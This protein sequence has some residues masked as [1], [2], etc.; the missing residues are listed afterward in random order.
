[1]NEQAELIKRL[2]Q[3]NTFRI[4][5]ITNYSTNYVSLVM[6]GKKRNDRIIATAKILADRIDEVT[7]K[8]KSEKAVSKGLK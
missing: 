7:D 5:K 3:G 1:M 8:L 4:A 2:K 6:H